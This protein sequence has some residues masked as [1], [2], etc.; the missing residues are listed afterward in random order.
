MQKYSF[1]KYQP[2]SLRLWHW[3]SAVVIFG[4][5]G[6]VLIR[7]TFLNWRTNS[8]LIEEKLKEAGTLITSDLAKEVAIAIRNPLWDWHIYLGF[9][10]GVLF[11]IRI[12]IVFFVEKKCPGVDALK[13][14]FNIKD[15]PDKQKFH[16]FHFSVV[17]LSYAVFYFATFI[18]LI[19]GLLL[20]F[21]KDIDLSK[22]ITGNIKEIHE[23]MMWFFIVFI[24]G[25]L[26]GV[27][28]TENK[29]EPGLASDMING[30]KLN[31]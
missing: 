7:K 23:L 20:Y 9:T 21:K 19:S 6:T 27:I 4:L 3:S 22:S 30:G 25:H 1:R 2:L 17:K 31:D 12:S 15:L 16:A 26:L 10:L 28:M 14:L 13:N 8:V 18:M 24:L 5:L 11:I 29:S